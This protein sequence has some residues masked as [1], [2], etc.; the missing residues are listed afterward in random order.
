M[1]SDIKQ[2]K[3]KMPGFIDNSDMNLEGDCAIE[4]LQSS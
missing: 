2:K 1:K 3:L 4:E